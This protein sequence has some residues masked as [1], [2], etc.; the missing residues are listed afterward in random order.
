M[1]SYNVG[2]IIKL[3]REARG[4][5]QE[6]LSDGVCSVQTLSRIE[7]GKVKVKR[8]TYQ[9]LMEKMGREGEKNY[10]VLST[11]DFDLLDTMV[12]VNNMLFRHEYEEAEKK[13]KM[14]KEALPM[15]EKINYIFVREC[16]LIIDVSLNRISKE[17][18]LE[19][20]EKLIA[21]TIPDYKKF[22]YKVYPFFHEEII[23]LM[24][25]GHAYSALG[26]KKMAIDIYY[27]LIRSMNTGYM[28]RD[29]T[30]QITV[31]LI[32]S[33][34]RIWGGLGQ[35]DRA[36]RMSWNAIH[37]AKEHGLYTVLPKCYGEIAW[38][39]MKQIQ[40]GERQESDRKLCKQ[41]L[42]QGY[43]VA[44]LSR[45]DWLIDVIGR[46]YNDFFNE[47]IYLFLNSP[48][49]DSSPSSLNNSTCE[50]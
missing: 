34:A 32:S 40:K 38:N 28:K 18:N 9:Q 43:A 30:I 21:L 49:G 24:N 46:I 5:S 22:L 20:L 8:T 4:I 16:E 23:L 37:K 19:E 26:N 3:T 7:N 45:E 29:D 2:L 48:T 10:S 14:L 41:Y 47:E 31:M 33:A 35:R 1:S 39:M 44:V 13:L 6:E 25:I 36:I 11:D 42:R 15:G 12:E 27:M 50:S 17:E